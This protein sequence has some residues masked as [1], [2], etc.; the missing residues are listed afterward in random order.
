MSLKNLV[1]KVHQLNVRC[2]LAAPKKFH[3]DQPG[4]YLVEQ[5]Y[6]GYRVVQV[7][8]QSGTVQDVSPKLTKNE[9]LFFVGALIQ[10][11][12]IEKTFSKS[13]M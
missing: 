1:E 9:L 7:I 10:G 8:D 2:G 13:T 4:S 6:S 3:L 11:M 5:S 12:E